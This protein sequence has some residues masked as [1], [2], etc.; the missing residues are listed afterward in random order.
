MLEI[1]EMQGEIGKC[2]Q[3]KLVETLAGGMP[4]KI[5]YDD[6]CHNKSQLSS[7]MNI[8]GQTACSD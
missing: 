2:T 4:G 3:M 5:S 6:F 8:G 1:G 7:E